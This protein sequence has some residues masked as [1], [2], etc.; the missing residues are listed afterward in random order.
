MAARIPG[1]PGE[2]GN[3]GA[4]A[5]EG[6]GRQSSTLPPWAPSLTPLRTLQGPRALELR[7]ETQSL[8]SSPQLALRVLTSGPRRPSPRMTGSMRLVPPGAGTHR[9]AHTATA[10]RLR[11]NR[12][13]QATSGCPTQPCFTQEAFQKSRC[14]RPRWLRG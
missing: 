10:R 5:E 3:G 13:G 4:C 2:T 12:P 1:F 9:A 8:Q 14:A 7:P 11:G 6:D